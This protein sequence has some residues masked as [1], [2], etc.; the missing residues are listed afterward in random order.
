M[1]R[2]TWAPEERSEYDELLAEVVASGTETSHRLDVFESMLADAIQAG[3]FWAR[4]VERSADA[5]RLLGLAMDEYLIE[6]EDVA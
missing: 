3:R 1:S 4:D 6:E 5:I 2:F